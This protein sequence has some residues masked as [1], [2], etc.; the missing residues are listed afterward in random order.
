METAAL[1]V[2]AG[3]QVDE[4]ESKWEWTEV[5]EISSVQTE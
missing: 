4:E 3:Q 1:Q 5:A 2:I